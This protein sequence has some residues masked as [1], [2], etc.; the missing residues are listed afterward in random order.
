[1]KRRGELEI[2]KVFQGEIFRQYL[3]GGN[4]K[5]CYEACAKV[6]RDKVNVLLEKGVGMSHNDIIS[7]LQESKVL[8]RDLMDYAEQK[9]VAVTSARRL[10]EFLGSSSIKGKGICCYFVISEKPIGRPVTDS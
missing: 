6:A 4:L 2:V 10:S 7:N 3:K 5:E 8:S 1:M 9:G